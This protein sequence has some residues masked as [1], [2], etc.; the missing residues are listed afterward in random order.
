MKDKYYIKETALA[1]LSE[2]QEYT[3]I[4]AAHSIA[5]NVLCSILIELGYEDVVLEYN[6]INKWYA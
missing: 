2:C 6:K 5:D 3:D 4:E 1:T